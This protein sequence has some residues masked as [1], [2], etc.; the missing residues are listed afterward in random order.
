MKAAVIPGLIFLSIVCIGLVGYFYVLWTQ[1]N[2]HGEIG[3]LP[4]LRNESG[5]QLVSKRNVEE[6]FESERPSVSRGI[7]KPPG[8]PHY[9]KSNPNKQTEEELITREQKEVAAHKKW[10]LINLRTALHTEGG[11]F[12][13]SI[14]RRNNALILFK[15]KPITA[16]SIWSEI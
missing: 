16:Q 7:A 9:P 15:F 10:L 5:T 12:V 6:A 2:S 11:P 3:E 1:Y 14:P 8:K 4:Q 13:V